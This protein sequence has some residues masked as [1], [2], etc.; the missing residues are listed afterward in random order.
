MQSRFLLS[1]LALAS[2][3]VAAIDSIPLDQLQPGL[4]KVE[5]K[6]EKLDLNPVEYE[7]RNSEYCANPKKEIARV[8]SV[9]NFLCKAE[10]S[11]IGDNRYKVHAVCRLPGIRGENTTIITIVSP[12]E[13]TAEVDTEGTKFG[14]KQHR[15][16]TITAKRVSDC[17][18]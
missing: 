17:K 3:P 18:E 4:W 7:T 16:E 8:L 13:Y 14:E 5:R 9:T 15:K 12:S 6:I 10:D 2:L 11:K 1:C